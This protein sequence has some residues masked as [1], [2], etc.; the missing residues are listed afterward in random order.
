MDG[1]PRLD[2]QRYLDRNNGGRPPDFI[3]VLLGG[4]DNFSATEADIEDRIDM[5]FGYLDRLLAA[6]RTAAPETQIARM[7]NGLHPATPGCYQMGDAIYCW[8]KSRLA[9]E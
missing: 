7:S 9:A 1:Q 8:I 5:M 2:F 3:T 6:F 4:N